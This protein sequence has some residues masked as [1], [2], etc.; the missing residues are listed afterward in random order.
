LAWTPRIKNPVD[1]TFRDSETATLEQAS[2]SAAVALAT[3]KRSPLPLSSNIGIPQSIG[4]KKEGFSDNCSFEFNSKEQDLSGTDNNISFEMNNSGSASPLVDDYESIGDTY[5]HTQDSLDFRC[6]Q[7][8]RIQG[9][10]EPIRPGDV[11][12]TYSPIGIWG[13]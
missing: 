8:R 13:R 4:Y 5:S 12:E 7:R 1:P 2:T 9:P 10:R 6:K 3:M 11:I